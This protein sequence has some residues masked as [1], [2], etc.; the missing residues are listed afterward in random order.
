MYGWQD[1]SDGSR[2]TLRVVIV[3]A[4]LVP[5]VWIVSKHLNTIDARYYSD[6]M[7]TL[8]EARS[9][10]LWR[11]LAGWTIWVLCCSEILAAFWPVRRVPKAAWVLVAMSAV[12]FGV[13]SLLEC[14]LF[15]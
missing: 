11:I 6:G 1:L 14:Q 5:V 9:R 3:T 2:R 15:H 7:L 13:L 10:S 4:A 12:V 8:T